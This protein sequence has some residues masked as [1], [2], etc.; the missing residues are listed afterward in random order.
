MENIQ[1]YLNNSL[2]KHKHYVDAYNHFIHSYREYV[3]AEAKYKMAT[4]KN[5]MECNRKFVYVRGSY[6]YPVTNIIRAKYPDKPENVNCPIYPELLI[7]YMTDKG[8]KKSVMVMV[9]QIRETFD[10]S[11]INPEEYEF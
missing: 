11:N 10:T 4:L 7:E 5:Q 6:T 1:E 9:Y 2:E 8:V 3:Y